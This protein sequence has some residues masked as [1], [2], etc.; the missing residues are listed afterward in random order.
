MNHRSAIL[1]VEH[2]AI[3]NDKRLGID[4]QR[5]NAVDKDVATYAGCAVTHFGICHSAQLLL[6]LLLY[7]QG[8]RIVERCCAL[9][10]KLILV[11]AV[12]G[13]E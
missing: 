7:I 13:S 9:A 11:V 3:D 10:T 2:N 5:I 12:V 6:Y 4:I 8:R 1:L